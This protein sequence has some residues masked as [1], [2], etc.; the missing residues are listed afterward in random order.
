MDRDTCGKSRGPEFEMESVNIKER[1]KEK[2]K[3]IIYI[4]TMRN[5]KRV[6]VVVI[7]SSTK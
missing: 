6:V 2:I 4:R 3:K 7:D 1:K 5:G